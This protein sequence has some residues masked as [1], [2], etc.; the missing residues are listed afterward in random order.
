MVL[1]KVRFAWGLAAFTFGSETGVLSLSSAS[2]R[3]QDWE[4][5]NPLFLEYRRRFLSLQAR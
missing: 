3:A 2:K 5:T 4:A 1:S